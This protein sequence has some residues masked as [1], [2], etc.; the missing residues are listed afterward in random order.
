M[1]KL[2]SSK[3]S[4]WVRF[5]LPLLA[6]LVGSLWFKFTQVIF[7][8][9]GYL[10][11]KFYK[12]LSDVIRCD[13]KIN[14]IISSFLNWF[15]L[16]IFFVKNN[17]S[18][19]NIRYNEWEK[20]I[21]FNGFF[22]YFLDLLLIFYKSISFKFGFKSNQYSFFFKKKQIQNN[23]F[24]VFNN[25]TTNTTNFQSFFYGLTSLWKHIRFWIIPLFLSIF[26]F[27]YSFFLRSLPFS[28][29]F[30]GYI[31]ILNMVYLLLSGFVFF[32]K[33]YQYRL[34]TSAIQRF[35][36]RSLMVFW[37]IE[38]GLFACFFYLI[39]NA[40]QEPVYVYDNIQVYKTHFYSWRYF[41]LKI[42]SSTLLIVFTYLLLLSV[43][44]NTFSKLNN[45]VLFITVLL[46]YITWLEFYQFFHLMNSYGTS[47][48]FY[49]FS[50]HIWN[51]ELEFRRTRIVNHYVTIGLVAKFWHI[52]FA[53]VF[54]VFF[55]LRALESSRIRY[56]LLS[57]NI[58][59]FVIIYVMSW[60]YMYPWFKYVFRKSLDMPYFWFFVNNRKIAVFLFF[61]DIKL[62]YWGFLDFFQSFFLKKNYFK[63]SSFFYWHESS[64]F[65]GSF[66]FRKHNIRDLFIRNIN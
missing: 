56:P 43:K 59:N 58:Q 14:I 39:L 46:L 6:L 48:W 64:N 31:L 17:N 21:L 27:Y 3:L 11:I 26:F 47:N 32:I 54:W 10:W 55:I 57:A 52:I 28:K 9:I 65:L 12:Y 42:I 23:N 35:W 24:Y 13:K 66:Q 5:P 51:L 34:Y 4:L 30:F 41:L 19:R 40:N 15:V 36:R 2:Q 22:F 20:K 44:W 38:G 62:Y 7:S 16:Y 1:V 18:D 37:I 8:F 33:K 49:D 25:V 60:L 50:E 61:N 29:I 53:V 45:I 63:E